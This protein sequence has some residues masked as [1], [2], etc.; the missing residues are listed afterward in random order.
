MAKLTWDKFIAKYP[1][2]GH[3]VTTGTFSKRFRK[4]TGISPKNQLKWPNIPDV[5]NLAVGSSLSGDWSHMSESEP[6]FIIKNGKQVRSGSATL[7]R[8]V[9]SD[10]SDAVKVARY[11]RSRSISPGVSPE[12]GF[13]SHFQGREIDKVEYSKLITVLGY[14]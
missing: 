13:A 7:Y 6:Q 2:A 8:F 9:F 4:P 3:L 1:N 10:Q 12:P 11:L 14:L 5:V